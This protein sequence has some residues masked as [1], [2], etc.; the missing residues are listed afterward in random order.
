MG[1]FGLSLI[2]F[3]EATPERFFAVA[4]GTELLAVC[5]SNACSSLEG[6]A[7]AG[8]PPAMGLPTGAL[9]TLTGFS[10]GVC[11]T[12]N[13]CSATPLTLIPNNKSATAKEN[14]I[15]WFP[16]PKIPECRTL[17]VFRCTQSANR[18]LC[19]YFT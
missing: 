7:V 12:L 19:L 2:G 17:Q 11:L 9:F 15:V 6:E 8:L 13:F 3:T 4:L 14:L 16:L 5:R 10:E 1:G 18:D